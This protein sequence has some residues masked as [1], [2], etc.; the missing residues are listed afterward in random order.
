MTT[1][2]WKKTSPTEWNTENGYQIKS[3]TVHSHLGNF[4]EFYIYKDGEKIEAKQF[5]NLKDA[6][7]EVD[8]RS[9]GMTYIDWLLSKNNR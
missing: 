3:R 1:L 6:K 2:K 8:F 9:S 7:E 4:E 5:T